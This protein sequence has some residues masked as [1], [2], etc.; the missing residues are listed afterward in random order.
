MIC[1]LINVPF[2][3]FAQPGSGYRR[4]N[5]VTIGGEGGWDYATVDPIAKRLY[6]SHGDHVEVLSTAND[7][8]V[9]TVANTAGIHGV[10][11]AP[12]LGRGFTSNGRSNSCSIFDLQTLKVLKEVKTG[13]KPDAILYDGAS[14]DV[15]VFNGK[16][17][18]VTVI[19]AATGDVAGT[20][21]LEGAPEFAVSDGAGHVYFN[22][23]DRSE[24]GEIDVKAL[25]VRR[26]WKLGTGEEPTGLAIDPAHRRL[27]AGCHNKLMV[28]MNADD[29][30]IVASLPIGAGVD[31]T[32]FDPATG[33][34]FASNGDGTLTVVHEDSADRFTVIDNVATERGARTM[35]LD[36]VTHHLY[37]PTARFEPASGTTEP[38][39]RPKI[40]S[41]SFMVLDYAR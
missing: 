13:G 9:G 36:P 21:P 28:V 20:I 15:F 29:G 3:L 10:A 31:A 26:Y 7:S 39:P 5:T 35:A 27:F 34:A 18:D 41:G 24:I 19:T 17:T 8:V 6:L 38:H 25:K 32:A 4:V 11:L 14:G 40:V 23:E 33:F 22:V 16:S 12:A 2:L 1:I 37:L 30:S